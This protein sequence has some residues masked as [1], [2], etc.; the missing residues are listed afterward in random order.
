MIPSLKQS[1]SRLNRAGRAN[2]LTHDSISGALPHFAPPSPKGARSSHLKQAV[3]EYPSSPPFSKTNLYPPP[4]IN[5]THAVQNAE[6]GPSQPPKRKMVFDG[7]ELPRTQ[8]RRRRRIQSAEQEEDYNSWEGAVSAADLQDTIMEDTVLLHD[9]HGPLSPLS[10]PAPPPAAVPPQPVLRK[11]SRHRTPSAKSKSAP[12]LP[13]RRSTK[14]K[15]PRRAQSA[16]QTL[17][18]LIADPALE[19]QNLWECDLAIRDLNQQ[20]SLRLMEKDAEKKR[21]R[22]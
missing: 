4:S 14:P 18:E 13:V 16:F 20:T 8:K 2:D 5:S 3:P 10:S 15:P 22:K 11:S 7:V 19:T 12:V 17:K 6:A 21:K 1:L 9:V